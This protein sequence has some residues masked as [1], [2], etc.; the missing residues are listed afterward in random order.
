MDF[1][2][3]PKGLSIVGG[4]P[5]Q[6]LHGSF[7][8]GEIAAG[9]SGK[10]IELGALRRSRTHGL[11]LQGGLGCPVG[12][13]LRQAGLSE[14]QVGWGELG[15]LHGGGLEQAGADGGVARRQRLAESSQCGGI[16]GGKGVC[17]RVDVPRD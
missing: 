11:A 12:I 5:H 9:S 2:Q 10:V 14:P 1:R 17:I 13:A 8:S 7:A 4:E 3:R 6:F 16:G 15:I